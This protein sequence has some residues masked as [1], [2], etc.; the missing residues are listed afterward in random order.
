ML[1]TYLLRELRRRMRQS[2]VDSNYAKSENLKVGSKI[3]A[4]G[5]SFTMVGIVQAAESVTDADAYIPLPRAQ[6]LAN[7]P[8]EVNTIYVS[9]ASTSDIAAVYSE[10]SKAMP[11]ATVTTSSDLA[12]EVSDSL[13][14]A[15]TLANT[16]G[17]WLAVAVLVAAFFLASILTVFALTWR[18][19]E[20]GT[21]KA[22]GWN[23]GRIIRQIMARRWSSV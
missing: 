14:S 16:L 17:K 15:S 20:F 6:S 21:L 22:I 18:V 7:M 12:N 8:G 9:A 3:S 5:T 4:A 23:S 19:R 1:I 13:S 11:T 2:M 10:I